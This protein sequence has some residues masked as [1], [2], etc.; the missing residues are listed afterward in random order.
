MDSWSNER[1]RGHFR[2]TKSIK[3]GGKGAGSLA[4]A[5]REVQPRMKAGL[6]PQAAP[7]STP[8]V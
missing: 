3:K 8:P 6:R 7:F 1:V 2:T 4:A 5:N